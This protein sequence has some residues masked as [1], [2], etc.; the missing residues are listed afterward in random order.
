MQGEALVVT[1]T[2]PIGPGSAGPNDAPVAPVS[3]QPGSPMSHCQPARYRVWGTPWIVVANGA[4]VELLYELRAV[5]FATTD[6]D[7][8]PRISTLS[9]VAIGMQTLTVLTRLPRPQ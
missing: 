9:P 6:P 3:T 2:R 7:Q 1:R 8:L 4:P 5:K